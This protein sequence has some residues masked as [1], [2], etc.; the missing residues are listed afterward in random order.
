M[1]VSDL[2]HLRSIGAA[3]SDH[4]RALFPH[5]GG[6]ERI[7]I[8]AGGDWTK[9]I[10]LQAETFALDRVRD[11]GMEWNILSEEIGYLDRG[12]DKT[13][14]IDPIDG[15]YNAVN[16]LPFY[17]TSLAIMGSDGEIDAGVVCD[18]P[19]R[20]SFHAER[21]RGAYLDDERIRTRDYIES[22]AVFSSFLEPGSMEDNRTLLSWPKRVRYFGAVS[23]EVCFV[24]K[25]SFDLFA[26]FS[27]IP[28][29]TDLA[30]AHLIL[31]EAGGKH[32]KIRTD[33]TWAD[34]H[35]FKESDIRGVLAIGDPTA[36]E[37]MIEISRAA[38]PR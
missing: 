32:M 24:A 22:R 33:G 37:R 20:R 38:R 1:G 13:L 27:R 31:K 4:I 19:M 15:T 3:V 14:I 25:G 12:S 7:G 30:A 10:D 6:G 21:G 23:L 34:Y 35:P 17:A 9:Q 36:A 28:R 18:I 8:G 16:A 11:M 29:I 5:G 2:Q 26:L